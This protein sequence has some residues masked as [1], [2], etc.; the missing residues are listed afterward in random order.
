MRHGFRHVCPTTGGGE[1]MKAMQT[2]QTLPLLS[3]SKNN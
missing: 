2:Q 3:I 1:R